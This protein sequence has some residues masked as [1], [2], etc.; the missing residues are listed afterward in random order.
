MRKCKYC[1]KPA[2]KNIVKNINKGYCRT[3]GSRD[4]LKVG[5]N[6][7]IVKLKKVF[8]QKRICEKCSVDYIATSRTQRWCIICSP[9][10]STSARLQRYNVSNPEFLEMFREQNGLCAICVKRPAVAIDHCHK[11]K[12]IRKLL[13]NGCNFGLSY[14]ENS[15]WMERAKIYA[16]EVESASSLGT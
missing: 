8:S 3:C 4:C 16:L 9:N 12:K 14:F 6:D 7:P 13:C 1:D 15:E 11:T 5:Y 2:K 10:R